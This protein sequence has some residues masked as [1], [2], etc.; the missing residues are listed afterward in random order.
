MYMS[1]TVS[2]LQNVEETE[3]KQRLTGRGPTDHP[4][5]T[6]KCAKEF[7]IPT[8]GWFS[9]IR[10]SFQQSHYWALNVKSSQLM[11]Q[12]KLSS[13]ETLVWQTGFVL[14]SY[15]REKIFWTPLQWFQSSRISQWS[16][17]TVP[18]ASELSNAL[19]GDSSYKPKFNT[20]WTFQNY[21]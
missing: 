8:S 19:P 7:S 3:S 1:W 18:S 14:S 11:S 21:N 20:I 16:R 6:A 17:C 13:L 4:V 15:S 12:Q 10:R 5:L 9:K 2:S